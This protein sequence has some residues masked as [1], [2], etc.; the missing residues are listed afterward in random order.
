MACFAEGVIHFGQPLAVPLAAHEAEGGFFSR[1]DGGLVVGVDVEHKPRVTRGDLP[2]GDE[3]AD[4][5][6]INLR[7]LDG[8]VRADRIE[9][10]VFGRSF[11]GAQERGE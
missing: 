9:Q 1:L 4:V 5:V 3:L 10:G 8:Q 7:E 6:R 2:E 11:L